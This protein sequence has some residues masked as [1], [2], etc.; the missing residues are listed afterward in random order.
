MARLSPPSIVG[1]SVS[2]GTVGYLP[3]HLEL[4]STNA[5]EVT[6]KRSLDK[7]VQFNNPSS[8]VGLDIKLKIEPVQAEEY[9]DRDVP[10]SKR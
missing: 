9:R 5:C 8:D 4:S 6:R 3:G 10:A 1:R 2:K 7:G